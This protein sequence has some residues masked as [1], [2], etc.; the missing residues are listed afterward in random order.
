MKIGRR[1]K[2]MLEFLA[3]EDD[4]APLRRLG[5]HFGG[6]IRA[7]QRAKSLEKRGLVD[8]NFSGEAAPM[9]NETEKPL[10]GALRR[11]QYIAQQA[12]E[13]AHDGAAVAF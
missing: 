2:R 3:G 12:L 8:R 5:A 7:L 11:M 9:S 6:I 1:Q 4:M 10:A 13:E